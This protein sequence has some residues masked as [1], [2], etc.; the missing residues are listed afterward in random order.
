MTSYLAKCKL[1]RE[2]CQTVY[3]N[4]SFQIAMKLFADRIQ[5]FLWGNLTH[6]LFTEM[7]FSRSQLS[8]DPSYAGVNILRCDDNHTFQPLP[9]HCILTTALQHFQ[10]LLSH[11]H[12]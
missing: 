5:S 7:P 11:S 8:I 9:M 1:E 6:N 12:H 2:K 10:H 3:V 4:R